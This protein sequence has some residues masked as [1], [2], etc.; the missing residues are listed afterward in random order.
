MTQVSKYFDSNPYHGSIISKLKSPNYKPVE[1]YESNHSNKK[2][3]PLK[4]I[5][6]VVGDSF[7]LKTNKDD[8]RYINNYIKNESC[9]EVSNNS[10]LESKIILTYRIAIIVLLINIF[11]PGMGTIVASCYDS[12]NKT[13]YVKYGIFQFLS[14]FLII[15]WI[16][17][18][19]FSTRVISNVNK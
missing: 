9:L 5:P 14:A 4:L 13:K 6:N 1:D 10:N 3:A 8:G 15:G 16:W 2:I 7:F 18:I 12:N 17:A 19:L 11:L